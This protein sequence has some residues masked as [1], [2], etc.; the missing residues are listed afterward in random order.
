MALAVPRAPI[1]ALGAGG[2]LAGQIVV[3]FV[4][5][6][7]ELLS[8]APSQRDHIALPPA[9]HDA[10]SPLEGLDVGELADALLRA[11]I[12]AALSVPASAAAL[13]ACFLGGLVLGFGL[14]LRCARRVPAA[15]RG[16]P[17]LDLYP[18]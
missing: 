15:R 18:R 2:G 5:H 6:S 12:A 3:L 1:L 8:G 14:G 7:L 11:L 10:A 9:S 4:R 13:S 17:R 16:Q